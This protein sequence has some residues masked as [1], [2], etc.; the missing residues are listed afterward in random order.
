MAGPPPRNVH[1]GIGDGSSLQLGKGLDAA[2]HV[3]ENGP[4]G[5]V[6]AVVGPLAFL[7]GHQQVLHGAALVDV[8]QALGDLQEFGR[9]D[10]AVGG[11][12]WCRILCQQLGDNGLGLFECLGIDGVFDFEADLGGGNPLENSGAHFV[13]AAYLEEQI[14]VAELT[15]VE[16][17]GVAMAAVKAA[18]HHQYSVDVESSCCHQSVEQV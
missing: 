12:S 4:L 16:C 17:L 7:L 18:Q 11:R 9:V 3:V 2:V 13:A 5:F 10:S 15:V 1:L 8:P 6:Q 14:D